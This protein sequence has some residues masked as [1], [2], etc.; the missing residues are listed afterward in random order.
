MVDIR[1]GFLKSL[2]SFFLECKKHFIELL[3]S[4][5]K[6]LVSK[7]NVVLRRWDSELNKNWILTNEL[8]K[9]ELQQWQIWKASLISHG[10]NLTFITSF[11]QPSFCYWTH[12]TWVK[13]NSK[14][15]WIRIVMK[16]NKQHNIEHSNP[17]KPHRWTQK[18]RQFWMTF[19]P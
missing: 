11:D 14:P 4:L 3:D 16:L 9:V 17:K 2:I 15:I 18:A 7:E 19:L 8:I 6:F 10:G 12:L 1:F 13:I 5:Y